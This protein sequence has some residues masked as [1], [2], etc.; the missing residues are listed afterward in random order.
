M[1]IIQTINTATQFIDAFKRSSRKDQFSYEALDALFEYFDQSDN[2]VELDIIA[3]CCDWCEMTWEE[4][5]DAYNIELDDCIDDDAKRL[6]VSEY[7][8]ENTYSIDLPSGSFVFA[9]F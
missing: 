4:A 3:I 9:N 7:L 1:A 8:W 5:A 2:D 6:A